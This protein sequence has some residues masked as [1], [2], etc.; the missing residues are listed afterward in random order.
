MGPPEAVYPS[1]RRAGA[2]R[3]PADLGDRAGTGFLTALSRLPSVASGH[4]H[5]RLPDR[6]HRGG[7]GLGLVTLNVKHFPMRAACD[8]RSDSD[9]G[10][11]TS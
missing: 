7:G 3:Q 6:R 11:P 9:F 8:Q 4:R 5:R 2:E 10:V 1:I